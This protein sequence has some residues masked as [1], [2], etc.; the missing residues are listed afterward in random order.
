MNDR[1]D[2]RGRQV[3]RQW[4]LLRALEGSKQ[5]LDIQET[6]ELLGEDK[7]TDRTLYRDFRDLQA[8]GFPVVKEGKRWRLD[9]DSEGGWYVPMEPSQVVA[10][11]LAERLLDPLRGSPI[12]HALVELQTR[13]RAACHERIRRFGDELT[14]HMTATVTRPAVLEKSSPHLAKLDEAIIKEHRVRMGYKRGQG[15]ESVRVV[16][17]YAT[18]YSDG[19]LYLV[20]WCH[21]REDVITFAVP[22]ITWVEELDETFDREP[23]FDLDAFVNRG[24]GVL[25]GEPREVVLELL[26]EV[27][28]FAEERVIHPSQVLE[29]LEDGGCRVTLEV[30]GILE[31]AAWVVSFGGAV[32]ALEP[33]ELV[34]EVRARCLRGLEMH[35]GPRG[36]SVPTP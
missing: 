20:A 33:P 18:W 32:R 12:G 13:L 1:G 2:S 15:P 22:R 17:P 6:T 14:G 27:A 10:L 29:P 9:R 7:T 5:G 23:D 34:E 25:H 35:G 26:P 4:K 28:H 3:I 36:P 11:H 19:R 24:F 21:N 16:D 31:V 8:A 30:E